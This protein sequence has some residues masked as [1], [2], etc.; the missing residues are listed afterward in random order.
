MSCSCQALIISVASFF[1]DEDYRY[2][3]NALA[4]GCQRYDV[5]LHAYCLMT[6]HVHLLMTQQRSDVGISQVMQHVG[7]IY[8][9]YVNKTYRRTGTLWEGRHKASLVDADNYLFTCYRY[10]ELNPV[11]ADMVTAPDQYR[12]SS[13]RYHAWGEANALIN[14][15]ILYDA[16]GSN[17]QTRQKLY[18]QLFRNQVTEVDVHEIRQSLAYNHPLGDDRFK[19]QIENALGR[20]IGFKERGRPRSKKKE[21][22]A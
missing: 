5:H 21:E 19:N 22:G 9:A 3:L 20:R 12:W 14:D 17:Q 4:Q 16:L 1:A 11:V 10:I 13:Y 15:H 7:R 18:R 8:V 2:Y 6:N